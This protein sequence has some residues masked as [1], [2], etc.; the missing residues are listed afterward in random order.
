[1]DI[2]SPINFCVNKT[3]L[4]FI[5]IKRY[6]IKIMLMVKTKI[7][8]STIKGAGLGIFADQFI[9]KGTTTWRF[10]PG[11]DLVVPEDTLLQ[12]SEAAR[13]QFLNYCYVDKFTKHFILCFDDERFINHSR[14]PNIIQTLAESEL[15]G[16][17]IASRDIKKDE[18]LLC[19]YEDFDFDSFR[20]LHKLD[21]YAHMIDDEA[22]RRKEIDNFVAKLFKINTFAA[23]H[24]RMGGTF[25][26]SKKKSLLE[27]TKI[28]EFFSYFSRRVR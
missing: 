10:M 4:S 13:I 3:P 23:E 6:N 20:K 8:P 16:F 17:E 27:L 24:I 12:L 22:E 11:L 2:L 15:E 28:K 18:E 19:N 1:M 21:V 5:K 26:T 7:R 9:A 25:D 14:N